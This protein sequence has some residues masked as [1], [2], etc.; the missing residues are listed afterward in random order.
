VPGD[1]GQPARRDHERHRRGQGGHAGARRGGVQRGRE[2]GDREDRE[3]LRDQRERALRRREPLSRGPLRP[4][5]I[6][7]LPGR[8]PGVRPRVRD[9]VLRRRPGQLRVSPLRPRCLVRA[10]VRGRRAREDAGALHLVAVGPGGGAV[11]VRRRQ[12]RLDGAGAHGRRARDP[13]RRRAAEPPLS[14]PPE[15]SW[16]SP[17]HDAVAPA[18]DLLLARARKR[19][20]GAPAE[21][22]ELAGLVDGKRRLHRRRSPSRR[23]CSPA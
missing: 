21:V 6:P 23:L 20:P 7:T 13:A 12:P 3:G 1:G 9:R 10:R 19:R 14:P 2:G 4:L 15:P 18:V 22:A 11:D 16:R 5:Q 17:N 8:A